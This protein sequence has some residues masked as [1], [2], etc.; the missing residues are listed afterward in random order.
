M[1][2]DNKRD[3]YNGATLTLRFNDN[4]GDGNSNLIDILANG[5]KVRST[6]SEVGTS[7]STYVWGAW[8]EAPLVNSEGVPNNA[9]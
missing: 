2:F 9:R 8:A 4:G 1:V 5:F 6:S 7:G 3:G